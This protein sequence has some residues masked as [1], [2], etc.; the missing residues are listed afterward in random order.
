MAEVAVI[1]YCRLAYVVVQV[2]I[3]NLLIEIHCGIIL[4]G[5]CFT[6]LCF[7]KESVR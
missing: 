7:L 6:V 5:V 2:F 1:A 4:R 3:Y